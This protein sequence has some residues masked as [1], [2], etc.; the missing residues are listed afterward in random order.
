MLL[1]PRWTTWT[2]FPEVGC[3]S[4]LPHAPVLLVRSSALLINLMES[5][6]FWRW[7]FSFRIFF[8]LKILFPASGNFWL[9][10][11]SY[12]FH[13]FAHIHFPA[14][15]TSCVTIITTFW[16]VKIA[17]ISLKW[18]LLYNCE[19]KC[20]NMSD[21]VPKKC[22]TAKINVILSLVHHP[23]SH[24]LAILIMQTIFCPTLPYLT[25]AG[26]L[27]T[28]WN[29]SHGNNHQRLQMVIVSVT[30]NEVC[31]WSKPQSWK[32]TEPRY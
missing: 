7:T 11:E 5:K 30:N 23:S 2:E 27:Y 14:T 20:S 13:L 22:L 25:S 12:H 17:H 29:D 9:L 10:S 32:L 21:M 1:E 24:F 6:T 19:S 31:Q 15:L 18:S 8:D 16:H 4:N 3:L 26:E 28:W